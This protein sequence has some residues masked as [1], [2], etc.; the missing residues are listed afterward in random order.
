MSGAE[1]TNISIISLLLKKKKTLQLCDSNVLTSQLLMIPCLNSALLHLK[2]VD[3][4]TPLLRQ[5]E[6]DVF[7]T[8]TALNVASKTTHK[9]HFLSEKPP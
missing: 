8:P 7:L 6:S 5:R 9:I 4:I 3:L 1:A 2:N